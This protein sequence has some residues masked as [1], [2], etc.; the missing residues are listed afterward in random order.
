MGIKI[1]GLSCLPFKCQTPCLDSNKT[2]TYHEVA[3]ACTIQ[4]YFYLLIMSINKLY[5]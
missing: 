4:L 1:I 3:V 5:S 2:Q